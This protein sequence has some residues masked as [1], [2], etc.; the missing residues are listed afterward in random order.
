MR[1]LLTLAALLTAS[2]A[3]ALST[4][5]A[6][7]PELARGRAAPVLCRV[8]ATS[9]PTILPGFYTVTVRLRP[10]CPAGAVAD[11]R[12]ESHIGGTYPRQGFQRITKARPLIRTGIPWWWRVGWRS[13]S[14][15][16]Y[17]LTI[18]GMRRPL[19]ERSPYGTEFAAAT[20]T[21]Q[22]LYGRELACCGLRGLHGD[23]DQRPDDFASAQ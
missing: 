19:A 20:A 1:T 4:V 11:V 14:G 3:A 15:Q 16:V 23:A 5:P 10:E 9:Q 2:G 12:L 8:V 13:A 21:L 7:P 17:K 6:L 18:P 22:P